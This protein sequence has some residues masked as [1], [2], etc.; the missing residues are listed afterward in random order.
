VAVVTERSGA[1]TDTRRPSPAGDP[2]SLRKRVGRRAALPNGRAVVGGLLVAT[3]AVGTYAA[4]SSADDPPGTRYAVAARDVRVGEVLEAGDLRL[5]A[6]DAAPTVAAAAFA[7]G[8]ASLLVGQL[9]VAPLAAGDLVQRSAVVRPEDGRRARQLSFPIDVAAALA[10]T[11]EVGERVDVLATTGSDER[12]T[13]RV[14]AEGAV[15][16][17][18]LGDEDGGRIVVLLSVGD[19]ADLLAVTTAARVDDLTLVR[20]TPGRPG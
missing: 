14:V 13:T 4:W 11:V 20:T 15:V 17:A 6:M 8:D 5:V 3:A 7:A 10:G 2:A 1:V 18:L 9:T 19:D 12:A 16:A